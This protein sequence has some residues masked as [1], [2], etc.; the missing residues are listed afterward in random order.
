MRSAEPPPQRSRPSPR[1]S[2][3]RRPAAP[4][5]PSIAVL[6][7][8]NM[9]DDPSQEYFAEGIS[10][11]IITALSKLSQLFVIA[12]N[13]S[14]T[15]KGKNVLVAE[16]GKS[17]GYAAVNVEAQTRDQHS[18]LNWMRRMLTLR[19]NRKVFGRGTLRFLYP[20]NRRILAYLREY[21]DETVLCIANLAHAASGR[22]RS[23]RLR[24]A[25]PRRNDRP[26]SLP[27][28][29]PAQL[30]VDAAAIRLLLVR[31]ESL[32]RSRAPTDLLAPQE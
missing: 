13:S 18:L 15:F 17:L 25:G 5:K 11:D 28:D 2:S 23:F 32:R 29:Q 4:D 16:V 24:R 10:E 22:A 7:F 19:R 27:A 3:L 30:S 21:D 12:R 26:L 14:F 9:S 1:K 8:T 20:R 6:P 31:A